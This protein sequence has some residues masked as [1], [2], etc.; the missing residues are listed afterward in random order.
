MADQD[1]NSRPNAVMGIPINPVH[2]PDSIIIINNTL[3]A[4]KSSG[5][6]IVADDVIETQQTHAATLLTKQEAMKGGAPDKTEQRNNAYDVCFKDHKANML[7]VQMAADLLPNFNDAAALIKRNGYEVKKE[8]SAQAN[9]NISIKRKEGEELTVI[10]EVKAPDATKNYSIDWEGSYDNGL[11]WFSLYST[12]T[13]D[14]EITNVERFKRIIIRARFKIGYDNPT[15]WMIS[16]GL[17][18]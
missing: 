18:M 10:A 11:N 14:R 15:D 1:Y 9:P 4:L 7:L 5:D 12:P 13:C 16:N 17:D 6:H 2:V 8:M 3:S